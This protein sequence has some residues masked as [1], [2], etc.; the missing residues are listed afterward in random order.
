MSL[1]HQDITLIEGKKGF[2][3]TSNTPRESMHEKEKLLLEVKLKT[4]KNSK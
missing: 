3:S 2:P 1:F 4:F